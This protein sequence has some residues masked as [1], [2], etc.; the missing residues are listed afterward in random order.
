MSRS[1]PGRPYWRPQPRRRRSLFRRL[2]DYGLTLVLLGLLIL[3]TARLDRVET[4]KTEGAAI[5]NDGDSIT[6]GAERIRLRGIDAPEYAQICQRDGAGYPCGRLS[7][8]ALA[9]LI[10]GR[11]VACTGWQRDRYG[12]FLGDCTAGG[13]DLN[14]AQVAAGWAVAY[15]DFDA[16]QASARAA[17]VGIWAGTFDNPRDWRSRHGD[18]VEPTHDFLAAVGD[19]LREIFRFW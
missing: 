2:L 18:M 7:R 14:R 12:R 5:V 13:K 1:W 3:L 6:L 11:P 4:R 17:R 15:G 19:W 16:E 8:E 10:G 9:R